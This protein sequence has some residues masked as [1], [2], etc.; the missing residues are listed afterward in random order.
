MGRAVGKP[1]IQLCEDS[2]KIQKLEWFQIYRG[3][4][5]AGELLSAFE[6]FEV[7][8]CHKYIVL[9]LIAPNNLERNYCIQTKLN[10][11]SFILAK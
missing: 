10:G 4:E 6:M 9:Y 11:V 8:F 7:C 1:H 5:E 2:Y 3:M